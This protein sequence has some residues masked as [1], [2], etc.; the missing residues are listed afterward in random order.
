ML[1]GQFQALMSEHW[2]GHHGVSFQ[3]AASLRLTAI[4]YSVILAL[5]WMAICRLAVP[6]PIGAADLYEL[7]YEL[8][9]VFDN[10][11]Y[12]SIVTPDDIRGEG[13]DN[14]KSAVLK[15]GYTCATPS[16][17]PVGSYLRMSAS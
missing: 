5:T 16:T 11:T 1:V 2:L 9:Y 14:L 17:L 4:L 10:N 12:F 7:E 15:D 3:H 6:A 8:L 13:A